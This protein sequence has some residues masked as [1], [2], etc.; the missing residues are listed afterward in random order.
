MYTL[1]YLRWAV[2]KWKQSCFKSQISFS[3]TYVH[4]ARILSVRVCINEVSPLSLPHWTGQVV[5]RWQFSLFLYPSVWQ[6]WPYAWWHDRKIDNWPKLSWYLADI[7]V[8]LCMAM[9]AISKVA[10]MMVGVHPV[11]SRWPFRA[12]ALSMSFVV[13]LGKTER[14]TPI[15]CWWRSEGLMAQHGY[16]IE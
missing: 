6:I 9:V 5:I 8:T 11:I 13:S 14:F 16:N 15:A 3:I 12:P 10:S 7:W 4:K 2:S 1:G